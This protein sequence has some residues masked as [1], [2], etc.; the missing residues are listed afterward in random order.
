ML[1]K[2]AF[3]RWLDRRLG[4]TKT[5]NLPSRLVEC[6]TCKKIWNVN[7]LS[8]SCQ[9]HLGLAEETFWNYLKSLRN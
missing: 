8:K 5:P 3:D 4:E 7:D 1:F 6:K 9:H 2:G